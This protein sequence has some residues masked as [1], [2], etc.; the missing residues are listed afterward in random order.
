MGNLIYLLSDAYKEME[1]N[2]RS[3]DI[4]IHPKWIVIVFISILAIGVIASFYCSI[5][6]EYVNF[7]WETIFFLFIYG[8]AFACI[9]ALEQI[10]R[11]RYIDN[12]KNYYKRINRFRNILKNEFKLYSKKKLLDIINQC[13]YEITTLQNPKEYTEKFI[14]ISSKIIYPI[15]AV[16]IS[17]FLK[18]KNPMMEFSTDNI[19]MI[20]VM[21]STSFIFVST[22]L[23]LFL[24]IPYLSNRRTISEL[25]MLNRILNDMYIINFGDFE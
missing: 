14:S 2:I 7:K 15:F 25:K 10:N 11:K 8:L 24:Y 3:E 22:L 12:K 16:I 17:I 13:E 20:M 23:Y 6:N 18:S 4:K 9:W 21:I 19:V 5:N 1:K